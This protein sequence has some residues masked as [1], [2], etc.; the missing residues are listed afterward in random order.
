[1]TKNKE[2]KQSISV[3]LTHSIVSIL[4]TKS[5]QSNDSQ[6]DIIEKSLI[7][8]FNGN[9]TDTLKAKLESKQE[10]LDKVTSELTELEKKTGK[11]VSRTKKISIR[12]SLEEYNMIRN[13]AHTQKLSMSELLGNTLFTESRNTQIKSNIPAIPILE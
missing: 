7:D 5:Q 2:A 10:E 3:R 4:K 1:M 9:D 11:K 12:I 13:K 8:S 6:A